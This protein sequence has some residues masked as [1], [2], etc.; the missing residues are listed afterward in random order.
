MGFEPVYI[1]PII[2]SILDFGGSLKTFFKSSAVKLF[3]KK[4]MMSVLSFQQPI[5]FLQG[6]PS[7]IEEQ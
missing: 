5:M 2:L 1:E 3:F 6:N 4:E 7:F